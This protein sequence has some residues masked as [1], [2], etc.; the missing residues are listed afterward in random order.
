[1]LHFNALAGGGVIPCEY[2]DKFYRSETRMIVL[3]D[4]EDRTIV[5][6]FVCIDKTPERDGQTD[7]HTAA[8]ITAVCS[9]SNADEL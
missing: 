6:S 4:A 7:G 2:P 1:M 5:F 9:A 3:P 8:A